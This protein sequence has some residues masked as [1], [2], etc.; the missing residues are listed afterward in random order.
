MPR[1]NAPSYETS[2]SIFAKR[3]TE[4]MKDQ[5]ENQTTLAEKITAQYVTIQRQTISLYMNGQSKPDTER[6]TALAKVLNVSAD[7][8]LGLSDYKR[9][10]NNEKSVESTM[11]PERF[12]GFLGFY[13][14]NLFP[15]FLSIIDILGQ[16]AF[17]NALEM[18][19]TLACIPP[20]SESEFPPDCVEELEA[21]QKKVYKLTNG[22]HYAT[23]I[24]YI[25]NGL[26][27]AAQEQFNQAMRN[28]INSESEFIKRWFSL[29]TEWADL[30]AD[31]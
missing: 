1:K 5:G 13:Q 27:F 22:T 26:L 18:F 11:L 6:L 9:T 30:F 20:K 3:L 4:A 10:E 15:Q 14:E 23:N 17:L 29:D 24:G 16:E 19:S 7:W 28:T 2:N 8:L 21:L 25:K 31:K 12:I